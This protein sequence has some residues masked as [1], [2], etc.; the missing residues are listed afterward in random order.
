M[1]ENCI[2]VGIFEE[3]QTSIHSLFVQEKHTCE[4][5]KEINK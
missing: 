3:S 4:L 5:E 1:H 2:Q